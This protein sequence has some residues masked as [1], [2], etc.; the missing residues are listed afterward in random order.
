MPAGLIAAIVAITLLVARP[1]AAQVAAPNV[2]VRDREAK[3]YPYIF[4][5]LGKE[6]AKRGVD[7]PLPW[8]IGINYLYMKQGINIDRIG[9]SANDNPTQDVDFIKFKQVTSQVHSISI[10][11]DLWVLPFLN[12]YGIFGVGS[13]NTTVDISEPA[14][15]TSSVDQ[16]GDTLGFGF[17]G[18]F[19]VQGFFVI[20]DLNFSRTKMDKLLDPVPGRVFSGRVGK[21][22]DLGDSGMTLAFWGGFMRQSIS[23]DT[24]GK[25][26]LNEVLTDEQ[27][28]QIE[29]AGDGICD[30][31]GRPQACHALLDQIRER[32][33]LDTTINYSLDKS[34]A[35]PTN[36][37]VGAQLA[38]SKAWFVRTE[39]G[40]L[41]RR[42]VLASINYRFGI[43]IR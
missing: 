24:N 26:K 29:G 15:F 1:S 28:D 37:L 4:P 12:V 35:Q 40:F 6:L 10:R 19:A 3:E 34:L 27:I 21:N 16:N 36:I 25:I 22:F 2:H 30:D 17:T 8:G 7:L 18:A 11:P 20:A 39:L 5:I 33:P 32:D 14:T 13:A 41:T 9:L 38:L 43:P 23:A 31:S 42:S